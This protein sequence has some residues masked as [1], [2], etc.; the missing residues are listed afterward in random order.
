MSDNN[1]DQKP[2]STE[3]LPLMKYLSVLLAKYPRPI[4]PTQLSKLSKVSLAAVS[5]VRE[6]LFPMCS[7]TS[8][9]ASRRTLLLRNDPDTVARIGYAFYLDSKLG[10]FLRRP[11]AQ[12]FLRQWVLDGHAKLAKALPDYG[13]FFDK[14]DALF[15]ANL[16]I[17][18][19]ADGLDHLRKFSLV[20]LDPESLR[21]VILN[22][23][24]QLLD[25]ALPNLSQYLKDENTLKHILAIRDKLWYMASELAS[26]WVAG[27]SSMILATLPDEA[28]KQEYLAVYLHTTEFYLEKLVFMTVTK[29]IR[30]A[31]NT[32]KVPWLETYNTLGTIYVPGTAGQ[33]GKAVATAEQFPVAAAAATVGSSKGA[34]TAREEKEPRIELSSH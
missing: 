6:K 25:E 2:D 28:T 24:I 33:D 31:A 20:K 7:L 19:V 17:R 3:L 21:A 14:D 12:S 10:L 30:E 1:N 15:V 22:Q 16:S 27:A 5:K 29:K 4:T 13:T 9:A 8:L 23:V 11:Y 32:V 34:G 18:A 26:Q